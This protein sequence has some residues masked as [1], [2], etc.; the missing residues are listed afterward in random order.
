VAS[1]YLT[2]EEIR[3]FLGDGYVDAVSGL[4]GVEENT[5]N[6][7]ATSLI[8]SA[9]RGAGYSPSAST[10][11][12]G[13]IEPIVKLATMGAFREL[14]ASVPEGSIP[15]PENWETNPQKVAYAQFISGE[16]TLAAEPSQVGAVGGMQFTETDATIEGSR[17]RR[18]SREE[19]EGY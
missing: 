7:A 10:D 4:A 17:P 9:M 1:R 8:A 18:A 12:T 2:A 3:G 19:L 5:L 13:D 11:G 16:I 14:L 15:L 6:E